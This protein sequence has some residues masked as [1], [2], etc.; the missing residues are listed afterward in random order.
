MNTTAVENLYPLPDVSPGR[1]VA[2]AIP[3]QLWALGG[4]HG[5]SRKT[6]RRPKPNFHTLQRADSLRCW[7]ISESLREL[8]FLFELD[9]LLGL[10]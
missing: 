9:S 5:E 1:M 6:S 10:W 3:K 4:L 2:I 7:S 8:F